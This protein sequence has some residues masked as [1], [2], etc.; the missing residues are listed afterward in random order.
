M[1]A[2][3]LCR[4]GNHI[5]GGGGGGGANSKRKRMTSYSESPNKGEDKKERELSRYK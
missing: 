2:I 4:G 1:T 5:G 3:K